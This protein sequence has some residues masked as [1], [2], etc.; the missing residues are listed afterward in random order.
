M[1]LKKIKPVYLVLNVIIIVCV[2][3]I[4]IFVGFTQ[5]TA[6][7]EAYE[8]VDT[9]WEVLYLGVIRS[10][11]IGEERQ[12]RVDA[13][14]EHNAGVADACQILHFYSK[15]CSA[16]MRVEPWLNAF[17]ERYPEVSFL[18]YELH[19][20]DYLRQRTLVNREYSSDLTLVPSIYIC[21]TILL[22]VDPI[23][24]AF[25]PMALAVYNLPVR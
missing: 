10:E 16:C 4:L 6:S 20:A 19:D 8:V 22:G 11:I 25:E 23:E 15:T 21:G 18:S 1:D 5:L 24:K 17:R 13:F 14:I 7:E 12:G 9:A 3:A 2:A